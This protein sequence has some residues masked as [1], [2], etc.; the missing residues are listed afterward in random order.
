MQTRFSRSLTLYTIGALTVGSIGA[1]DEETTPDHEL[2]RADTLDPELLDA[3]TGAPLVRLST[4][5][6]SAADHEAS[7]RGFDDAVQAA[8]LATID[9]EALS[10]ELAVGRELEFPLPDGDRAMLVIETVDELLAGITSFSGHL[11]DDKDADFT[12]SIEGGQLVGSIRRD[13]YTWLVEPHASSDAHMI[14]MVDRSMLPGGEPELR[15]EDAGPDGPAALATALPTSTVMANG[16]VR[17]LFLYASD[18]VAPSAKAAN[19]IAAFNKSLELSAVAPNNYLM[20]AGVQPVASSFSG[21]SRIAIINSMKAR[22]APFAAIDAARKSAYADIVFLLVSEDP[23][24]LGDMP[25]PYGRVGGIASTAPASPFALSTSAYALG[26]LTALHEIGHV[27]GGQH[28]NVAN[29]GIARPRVSPDKTWMTIMGGYIDCKFAGLDNPSCIR[30]N[31]WSNPAQTYLGVPLG[32]PGE[33]DMESWLE[34]RMPIVS[35]YQPEPP[36]LVERKP[37]LPLMAVYNDDVHDYLYSTDKTVINAAIADYGYDDLVG[38]L[39]S[40]RTVGFVEG[41][42]QANTAEFKRYWKGAPQTDHFYTTSSTEAN[43]VIKAGWVWEPTYSAGYLYTTQ[44]PGSVPLYRLNKFT[45]Q[46][47]GMHYYTSS[48]AEVASMKAAGFTLDGV[49]GYVYSA[50]TPAVPGGVILGRRCSP[51]GAHGCGGDSWRNYY[52]PWVFNRPS[53]VLS[54][55]ATTQRAVFDFTAWNFLVPG[56]GHVA[57]IMRSDS[58]GD[59]QYPDNGKPKGVGIIIGGANCP[60][61]TTYNRVAVELWWPGGGVVD[62]PSLS[63]TRMKPGTKY[64]LDT[65]NTNDGALG[66]RISQGGVLLEERVFNVKTAYQAGSGLPYPQ[67][68]FATKVNTPYVL[69]HAADAAYDFTAYVENLSVTWQ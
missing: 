44:V 63:N 64:K 62:C 37:L 39:G 55:T 42:P 58:V 57:L 9:I 46:L 29:A 14:Q 69:I 28:E 7:R 45:A 53:T 17:V 20:A 27:L 8:L 26:D 3:D 50:A 43:G 61:Q 60:G 22:S 23:S 56:A 35:Q 11:A 5:E 1:C 18:V 19:I 15:Q 51:Q 12:F 34:A 30:L 59:M 21:Q 41:T 4:R 49:A 13:E 65:W 2:T 10:A 32:V 66:Y 6:L 31:R 36:P 38:P 54:P 24:A 33:R 47:D 52:F 67:P 16:N 48:A 40:F 68:N 25:A